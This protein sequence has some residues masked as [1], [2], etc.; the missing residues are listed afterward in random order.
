MCDDEGKK[1]EMVRGTIESHMTS[2]GTRLLYSIKT[3]SN[4]QIH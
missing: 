4:Y 1:Y 3:E 2:A